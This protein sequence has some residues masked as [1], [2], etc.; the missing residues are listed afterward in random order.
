MQLGIGLN[1][2]HEKMGCQGRPNHLNKRSTRDDNQLPMGF[3]DIIRRGR[4]LQAAHERER[5]E[6]RTQ[7]QMKVKRAADAKYA[8]EFAAQRELEENTQSEAEFKKT[9]LDNMTT[10]FKARL[11]VELRA[12]LREKIVEDY[13]KTASEVKTH[14]RA[15]TKL[16]LTEELEPL[17]K[18]ELGAKH[19][20][21]IKERLMEE[22]E[23]VVM[24]ELRKKCETGIKVQLKEEL[25]AEVKTE[26][27]KN[28]KDEVKKQMSTDLEPLVRAELRQ[29]YTDIVKAELRQELT[30]EVARE[31]TVSTH[32][33]DQAQNSIDLTDEEA[34]DPYE[35]PFAGPVSSHKSTHS[36]RNDEH[37][38]ETAPVSSRYPTY[39]A[40]SEEEPFESAP[41]SSGNS[42]HGRHSGEHLIRTGA[43][44]SRKK[45][46][47]PDPDDDD[48][49]YTYV[50]DMT[51]K[52]RRDNAYEQ[53]LKTGP[54][55]SPYSPYYQRPD[56][57]AIETG[58]SSS[59]NSTCDQNSDEHAFETGL[60]AT[61][62]LLK[63]HLPDDKGEYGYL[64]GHSP[65]KSRANNYESLS[66]EASFSEE[67]RNSIGYE[68]DR[69]LE[70]DH[71]SLEGGEGDFQVGPEYEEDH[72]YAHDGQYVQQIVRQS[73]AMAE[74][75]SSSERSD[76]EGAYEEG[77]D[78]VGSFE[79]GSD[80]EGRRFDQEDLRTKG[81]SQADA[82]DLLDSDDE[83][84]NVEDEDAYED[85]Y[86]DANGED[87]DGNGED[88]DGDDTL[89]EQAGFTAVNKDLFYKTPKDEPL[90]V[91]DDE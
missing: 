86:E 26:F 34:G 20:T 56:G 45:R 8:A 14:L 58:P 69:Q 7:E 3:E 33:Q 52:R 35:Q 22:L 28:Y 32:R 21:E 1:S 84:A 39:H 70:E 44:A 17:V 15:E 61:S 50:H 47:F 42:A 40:G 25:Q 37:P 67:E 11:E 30:R 6:L 23:P 24:A 59:H 79:D 43:A 73:G 60:S 65:K 75:W 54:M 38:F 68:E 74:S 78:A 57:Q 82:I 71:S 46:P 13:K 29:K 85:A 10:A 48:G 77:V 49:D 80:G 4:G 63:H 2:A 18:A 36:S 55:Y 76:D 5:E 87:E 19:A 9:I 41:V 53:P 62:R 88:E 12:E 16:Q 81:N 72:Y 83:E 51:S 31:V 66:S 90:F 27:E 91:D 89:V 64:P